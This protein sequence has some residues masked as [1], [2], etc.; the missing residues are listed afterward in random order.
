MPARCYDPR[1]MVTP[2]ARSALALLFIAAGALAQ[3]PAAATPVDPA[4][5]DQLK[6]LK[7]FVADTKMAADFQAIGLMQKLAKDA[8]ARNPKD[9]DKLAKGIGEVFRTGKVRTG[10]KEILYREASDALA[11]LEEDGSKEIAKALGD[12]RFKDAVALQAHMALALG[13][14]QD[15][16]QVETL[17]ELMSRSPHDELR[18]AGGEALGAYDHMDVK[19]RR[20]VVDKIIKEWGSLHSKAS[21]IDNPDPNAPIDTDSQNARKTLRVVEGKWVATLQKLTGVTQPGFLEWQRWQ[22]KNKDW[23]PPTSKKS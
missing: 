7:S 4:L 5:P 20:E 10:D 6:E 1:T 15:E 23:T 12:A 21:R 19:V 3:A 17:L 13:R 2:F 18:A 22:N 8:A 14:T 16:K 9:K 11:K